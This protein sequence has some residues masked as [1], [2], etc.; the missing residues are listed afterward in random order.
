MPQCRRLWLV[1]KDDGARCHS[2]LRMLQIGLVLCTVLHCAD[3]GLK[4]PSIVH[5]IGKKGYPK[6]PDSLIGDADGPKGSDLGTH[7]LKVTLLSW[8]TKF[9]MAI[10]LR[11]ALGYHS[12]GKD[13]ECFDIFEGR[14]EQTSK[15]TSRS[16]RRCSCKSVQPRRKTFR[17]LQRR[18]LTWRWSWLRWFKWDFI[19]WR[20]SQ[21]WK[22]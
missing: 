21:S 2:L 15:C 7:S 9:G 6:N 22:P 16:D 1:A 19:W 5:H 12:A 20:G 11:R 8:A 3:N 13:L 10:E 18:Q 14:H 4:R 17:V